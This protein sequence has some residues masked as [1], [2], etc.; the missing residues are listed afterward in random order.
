LRLLSPLY[1]IGHGALFALQ[2]AAK[3]STCA[4]E[5]GQAF[6]GAG[7]RETGEPVKGFL[8]SGS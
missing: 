8:V 6:A 2:Q 1:P 5:P 7:C 4:A 3:N